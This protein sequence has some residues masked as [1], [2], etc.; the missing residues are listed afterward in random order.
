MNHH[1]F[2]FHQ[3]ISDWRIFKLYVKLFKVCDEDDDM[4]ELYVFT[5]AW[6]NNATFVSFT[7]KLLLVLRLHLLQ[8]FPFYRMWMNEMVQ[9]SCLYLSILL[10][11]I[12]WSP[13]RHFIITY[14]HHTQS[15]KENGAALKY[16]VYLTFCFLW[17]MN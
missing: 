3:I 1:S 2:L 6:K 7:F 4:V 15:V 10:L 11:P 12:W 16:V 5:W 9:Q 13:I 17:Q 14:I 8:F